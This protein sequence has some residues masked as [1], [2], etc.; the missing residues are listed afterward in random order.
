MAI[1]ARAIWE[2]VRSLRTTQKSTKGTV[3]GTV[4]SV[5]SDRV[6][7]RLDG[8]DGDTPTES[9]SADA[10]VGDRVVVSVEDGT[11]RIEG[12]VSSPSVGIREVK[13]T[14]DKVSERVDDLGGSLTEAVDQMGQMAD[15]VREAGEIAQA[16]GQHHWDRSEDVLGD[17]A[18]TG[19]FV[20]ED[21]RTDFLDAAE[22]EWPDYGD[23]PDEKL[24]HNVLINS[25][26]M[27]V[28]SA[29]NNLV[30]MSKSAISFYDGLGNAASNIMAL[31]GPAGAR[32]G[33]EQ[34]NHVTIERDGFY[35]WD[36]PQIIAGMQKNGGNSQLYVGNASAK[37][38]KLKAAVIMWDESE[39]EYVLELLRDASG[40]LWMVDPISTQFNP[41]P[42]SYTN[43][44]G[45]RFGYYTSTDYDEEDYTVANIYDVYGR[46]YLRVIDKLLDHSSERTGITE[47]SYVLPEP[48]I[49]S[50][51]HEFAVFDGE[52]NEVSQ[53][54]TSVFFSDNVFISAMSYTFPVYGYNFSVGDDGIQTMVN[55]R[56]SYPLFAY[57]SFPI[58][59]NNN[60]D[61]YQLPV[62]P[63]IVLDESDYGLYYC[64][65]DNNA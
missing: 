63:C 5:G 65:S 60:K 36:G 40:F 46:L 4:T 64:I 6:W 49:P 19:A 32:I 8:G 42:S 7:V 13:E 24:Y 54:Y 11:A 17:G 1:D 9:P 3:A 52:L 38:V 35:V 56:Q 53:S 18:G 57:S 20:T 26:G 25:L 34:R 28:R 37:T 55:G 61:E 30:S 14:T 16:T 23:G 41:Q 22:N 39:N 59:G 47:H 10:K 21:T 15:V 31:F 33:D 44:V 62:L 2:L 29:L 43:R 12:S 58:D 51:Y 45:R 27:L 50:I 48:T